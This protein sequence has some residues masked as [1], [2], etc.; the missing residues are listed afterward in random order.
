MVA[1]IDGLNVNAGRMQEIPGFLDSVR[2]VKK[3]YDIVLLVMRLSILTDR[4]KMLKQEGID[5]F[6]LNKQ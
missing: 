2:T 1:V 4:M 5:F 6:T 3:K